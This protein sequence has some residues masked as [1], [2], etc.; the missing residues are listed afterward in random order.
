MTAYRALTGI[1]YPDSKTGEFTRVEAGGKIS[2]MSKAVA[3]NELAAGNIEPWSDEGGEAAE[4]EGE[5]SSPE[6][7]EPNTAG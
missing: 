7:E 3:E 5:S 6:V 1:D 2:G 4:A